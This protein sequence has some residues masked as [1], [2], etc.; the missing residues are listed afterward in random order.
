VDVS[1]AAVGFVFEMMVLN[2]LQA[3][4]HFGFTAAERLAP[5][6]VSFPLDG[7]GYTHRL[8]F[9]INHKFWSKRT[10]AELR[11]GEIEIVFLFELMI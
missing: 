6:H 4:A 2:I 10:R 5:M 1:P 7:R 11:A 9:W 3:M 8:E